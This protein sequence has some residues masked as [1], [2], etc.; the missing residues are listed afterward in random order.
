[1]SIKYDDKHPKKEMLE[2]MTDEEIEAFFEMYPLEAKVVDGVYPDDDKIEYELDGKH[3]RI[4]REYMG[5]HYD[6][7]HASY[8]MELEEWRN[9][10]K[11]KRENIGNSS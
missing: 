9:G 7:S 10:F 3:Y 5:E 8:C 1:M 4:R 6:I 11:R 2:K